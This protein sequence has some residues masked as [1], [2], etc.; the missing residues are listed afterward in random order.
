MYQRSSFPVLEM[1]HFP[2][3]LSYIYGECDNFLAVLLHFALVVSFDVAN[4]L[5]S[6]V[7]GGELLC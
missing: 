2:I 4:F 3:E 1:G 7:W 5:R 6:V